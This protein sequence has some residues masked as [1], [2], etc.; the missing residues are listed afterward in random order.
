MIGFYNYTVI[1]TYIG[2]ESS[3]VGMGLAMQGKTLA[4]LICLMFSGFC[5]LFDGKIARTKKDRTED[6]K[7]FGIQID[8]LCDVIC[9]GATPAVIGYSIGATAWWQTALLTAFV[10][11]GVI[12]LAYFN[13]MEGSRQKKTDE[14]LRSYKGLPITCAALIVPLVMC[15]GK[16]AGDAMPTVYSIALAITGACYIAPFTVKKPGKRGTV[17]ML[18][19]GVIFTG[20]LLWL[21]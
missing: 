21:K 12:R 19:L 13:V 11:C 8:S 4:A 17:I 10:L 18:V 15:F 1:L 3:V 9:F 7:Q 5:D 2:L 6:E 16:I 20:A 14:K